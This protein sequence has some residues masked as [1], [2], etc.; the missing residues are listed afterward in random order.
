MDHRV[1]FR[2]NAKEYFGIWIVNTLLTIV[3]LGAYTAWAK[4]RRRRYFA[5]NILLD[6]EPFEYLA[7]PW[8]IFR[9]WMI[10]AAAV[11]LYWIAGKFSPIAA[12]AV[13]AAIAAAIPWVVVKSRLFNS[14]N[15][16][17][18]NVR[19]NYL[20][21][22]GEAYRVLLG[23]SLLVPLTAGILAPYAFYRQKRFHVENTLYGTTPFRFAAKPGDY[24]RLFL[25][26]ALLFVAT[27]FASGVLA[28]VAVG[29]R[30]SGAQGFVSVLPMCFTAV[31]LFVAVYMKTAM[32]NLAWNRTE[33]GN[34]RFT[35]SLRPM[36]MFWLYLSGGVAVIL[37]LGLLFPWAIV[38]L[39]RY[40]CE[41]LAVHSVE[42]IE[43]FVAEPSAIGA[44]AAGEEIGDLFG[45]DVDIAF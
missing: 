18:R 20:P 3:S 28:A 45:L 9:G 29:G 44:G 42:G 1:S 15:Q 21:K 39:M 38:R 6:D 32:A 11:L 37:S 33:L 12:I 16:A 23:L 27:V 31:Y 10:A 22:Y 14:R 8:A 25:F 7:D 26:A 17:Y 24:Y 34:L 35:S 2:G 36:T 4:V 43:R 41:Q 19:F 13:A 40:R 5:G 30:R